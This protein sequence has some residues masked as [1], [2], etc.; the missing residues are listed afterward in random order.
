MLSRFVI[1]FVS[2]LSLACVDEQH[3]G[4][5]ARRRGFDGHLDFDFVV[6]LLI[7]H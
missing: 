2:G 6:R 5:P 4:Q 1:L 3:F 7:D